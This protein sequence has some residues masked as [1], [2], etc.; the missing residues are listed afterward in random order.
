MNYVVPR[1]TF[2]IDF[3]GFERLLS[4][5]ALLLDISIDI[6]SPQGETMLCGPDN[7]HGM[8]CSMQETATGT[9]SA[10]SLQL[11]R[12]IATSGQRMVQKNCDDIEIIGIPLQCNR[13]LVGVLCACG[14]ADENSMMHRAGTFLEEIANNI[15][16]EIQAQFET[17]SMAQELSNR[18]EELNLIYDVGKVLGTI[19]T[20]EEAIQFIVEHS[21][22]ALE[23][24]AVLVSIPGKD[25]LE[26]LCSSPADLTC[27]I[28]D[29]SFIAKIETLL[30][31]RVSSSD[32]QPAHIVLDDICDDTL[33]AGLMNVS[34]EIL[35]V[36]IKLKE[37]VS[38]MMYLINFESKKTFTAGDMRLL[39]SLAE[40][41]SMVIT[42]SELYSN[43][44]NFLF[45]VIKTLVHAIEA[46]DSYTRGHSERVNTLVITIAEAMDLSPVD[47]EA[48]SW[49]AILHDIGKIG[50][51]EKI[52]N[53]PGK[54][55]QEEFLRIQE[56]PEKGYTILKPIEQLNESL[57]AIRHHH[58]RYDGT[59]YPSG[60]K[61]EEIPLYA[62]IIALADTYDAMTSA[63][64][65]RPNISYED[66][67]AEIVSV[68]GTQLDP[69]LVQI[70]LKCLND[71]FLFTV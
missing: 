26:I 66:A 63:R 2:D 40:Q 71:S 3:Q 55:T 61:G 6:K 68:Q 7:A 5:L 39:T 16:H 22:K 27:D 34:L 12:Q 44:K 28:Y 43:L 32:V 69:E 57:S 18:Y 24:D 50:I 36:P 58:E 31:E 54:L 48:L 46:K 67:V 33:P 29:K 49:A 23:P 56:H 1:R 38:G 20:S 10:E 9:C 37:T 25:I 35:L 19:H 21:Q 13:E 51:S 47:Q 30:G 15:S 4:Q 17:E 62:R 45:N 8:S 41:I 59:G 14:R 53:K 42:N 64:S 70:F 11:F 52:L 65:Y 60:L